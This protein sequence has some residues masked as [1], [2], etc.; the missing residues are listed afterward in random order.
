MLRTEDTANVPLNKYKHFTSIAC[1]YTGFGFATNSLR[2][3]ENYNSFFNKY[4][5]QFKVTPVLGLALK[6]NFHTDYR[7]GIIVD[8]IGAGL[9]DY[10]IE[11]FIKYERNYSRGVGEKFNITSI[12]IIFI[13]EI[14]PIHQQFQG[15]F[16]IG[17]G[18]VYS[19]IEW[20]ENISSDWSDDLRV[21]SEVI[22]EKKIYP[23]FKIYT[24]VELGFDKHPGSNF[25]GSLIIETGY[26]LM[27]RYIEIY[28]NLSKQFSPAPESWSNSFAVFPGYINL[29]IGLS[30]NFQRRGT[31]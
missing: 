15:Y 29:S 5:G 27:L 24:G 6:F 7:L 28:S 16:G 31:K 25:L 11:N 23:A 10:Y 8:Y 9:N 21:S 14:N 1:I 3:F 30:F 4:I 20:N 18:I 2:F 12:P 22:K 19:S 26:T 17:A 13:A